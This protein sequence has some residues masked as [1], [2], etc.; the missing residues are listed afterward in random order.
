MGLMFTL[1][2]LYTYWE[3]RREC[4]APNYRVYWSANTVMLSTVWRQFK[5]KFGETIHFS[6]GP[7]TS[8]F[9]FVCWILSIKSTLNDDWMSE[10]S[11]SKSDFWSVKDE[12]SESHGEALANCRIRIPNL[13]KTK[14]SIMR[15]VITSHSLKGILTGQSL[16]IW[17]IS[18][19]SS[20]WLQIM[21]QT[22]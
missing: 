15:K 13:D 6:F 14:W 17:R 18:C 21:G 11:V 12:E 4:D 9:G 8:L 2:K 7:F 10:G 5:R 22:H 3:K 19:Y 20:F 1:L 16:C